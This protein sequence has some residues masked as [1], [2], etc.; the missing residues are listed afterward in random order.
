MPAISAG[1]DC[2]TLKTSILPEFECIL[3]PI[4]YILDVI[5]AANK[6]NIKGSIIRYKLWNGDKDSNKYII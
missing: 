6:L 2:I 4:P 1:V 3:T 5:E